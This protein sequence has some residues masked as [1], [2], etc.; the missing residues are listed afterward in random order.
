MIDTLRIVVLN[1]KK[2]PRSASNFNRHVHNDHQTNFERNRTN[3]VRLLTDQL[4]HPARITD[5]HQPVK[6]HGDNVHPSPIAL[7]ASVEKTK[8]KTKR[9]FVCWIATF[10][11]RNRS[12]KW[13][14]SSSLL[15]TPNRFQIGSF[16]KRLYWVTDAKGDGI[17]W[18]SRCEK[19][20]ISDTVQCSW[21]SGLASNQSISLTR[22]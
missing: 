9:D 3:C 22:D 2:A 13:C 20:I 12:K 11:N 8:Q 1:L 16:N 6:K 4:Y 10:L 15:S 19:D 7:I 5:I 18:R 17:N 21:S 14:N